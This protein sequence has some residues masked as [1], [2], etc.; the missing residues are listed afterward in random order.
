MGILIRDREISVGWREKNTPNLPKR[1][2]LFGE[3][4]EL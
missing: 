1:K 3:N 2:I 4:N